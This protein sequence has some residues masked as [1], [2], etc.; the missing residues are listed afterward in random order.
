MLKDCRVGRR[1]ARAYAEIV[2]TG[3]VGSNPTHFRSSGVV[4]SLQVSPNDKIVAVEHQ[5]KRD[6]HL[7]HRAWREEHHKPFPPRTLIGPWVADC[8]SL[9]DCFT[10]AFWGKR[11]M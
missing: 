8:P 1:W 9:G 4:L 3:I 10:G 6:F 11:G 5:L 7:C 2:T